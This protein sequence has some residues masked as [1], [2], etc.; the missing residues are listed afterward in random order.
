MKQISIITP[1]RFDVITDITETLADASINIESVDAELAGGFVVVV[2]TV[3]QYD[4]ALQ[5]LRSFSD[6]QIV[7]ED[8]I[9]VKIKN[10]PGA[11]ATIARRF[12]DEGVGLRSIRLIQRDEESCLVAIS[13]DRSE[14]ALALVADV[15]VF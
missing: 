13:A 3:D 8:A 1:N 5:S 7:T 2:L 4:L 10:V 11:L 9:L 14:A 12:T 6:M 15:L